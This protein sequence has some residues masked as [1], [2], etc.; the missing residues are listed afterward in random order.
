[1]AQVMKYYNHPKKGV[2]VSE[3]YVTKN[4]TMLTKIAPKTSLS[5]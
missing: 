5:L 3:E 1:M 4:L 2:G